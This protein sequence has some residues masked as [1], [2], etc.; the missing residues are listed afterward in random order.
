M[1]LIAAIDNNRGVMFNQRR[2][3]RDAIML[4]FVL[5]MTAN[6]KLWVTP[7]TAKLFDSISGDK[8]QVNIS[9]TPLEDAG[10]GEYC[11]IEDQVDLIPK[12]MKWVEKII[13]YNWNRDYP[14]DSYFPVLAET[15]WTVASSGDFVG[16][17]HEL[18]TEIVYDRASK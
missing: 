17:S 6:A 13:I 18:I 8:P 10:E 1:I 3:S 14:A 11:Y 9:P 7:Y 5:K 15:E 2:V 16:S 12:Y 4:C